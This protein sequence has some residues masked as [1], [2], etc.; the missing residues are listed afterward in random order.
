MNL[1]SYSSPFNLLDW[2]F[3]SQNKEKLEK[4]KCQAEQFCQR[5]G[6]YRMPFAWTAIHLM[7]IVSSAGSLERDSTEV[8]VGTGGTVS[9]ICMRESGQIQS[10]LKSW[11]IPYSCHCSFYHFPP[12][13]LGLLIVLGHG[14]NKTEKSMITNGF[15]FQGF[16]KQT[17]CYII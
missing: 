10:L 8:E 12:P 7:N 9:G 15:I 13:A 4:L 6:K 11:F 5:L 3:S 2:I 14:W 1:C 17:I 16:Y